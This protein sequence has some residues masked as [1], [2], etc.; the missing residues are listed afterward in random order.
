MAVALNHLG[1]IALL[2]GALA[3]AEQRFQRPAHLPGDQRRGGLATAQRA[4]SG[5][6]RAGRVCHGAA[7]A[8]VGA[9]APQKRT[10]GRL[11]TPSSWTW[12]KFS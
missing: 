10:S 11:S 3:E 7:V 5:R 6:L 9:G 4:G 8:G 1:E 2:Q 12:P